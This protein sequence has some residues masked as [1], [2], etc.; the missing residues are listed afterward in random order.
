MARPHR[1]PARRRAQ[2]AALDIICVQLLVVVD[3]DLPLVL[4][5]PGEWDVYAWLTWLPKEDLFVMVAVDVMPIFC[6]VELPRCDANVAINFAKSRRLRGYVL[7]SRVAGRR[8]GPQG[9]LE[10]HDFAHQPVAERRAIDQLN[11]G[12]NSFSMAGQSSSSG[13]VDSP[14]RDVSRVAVPTWQPCGVHWVAHV[15]GLFRISSPWASI[16]ADRTCSLKKFDVIGIVLADNSSWHHRE[17]RLGR[18]SVRQ[19]LLVSG[20]HAHPRVGDSFVGGAKHAFDGGGRQVGFSVGAE[21]NGVGLVAVRAY[22]HFGRVRN[23]EGRFD[24]EFDGDPAADSVFAI[25]IVPDGR[26]VGEFA[27]DSLGVAREGGDEVV[28]VVKEVLR[29]VGRVARL[30]GLGLGLGMLAFVSGL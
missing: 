9:L 11:P 28:G 16:G 15:T 8:L 10:R 30:T 18:S 19:P 6:L 26:V 17:A 22:R 4:Q 29:R 20:E 24:G 2:D 3:Q 21:P 5:F 25:P 13:V 1:V 7:T 27:L 12:L 14:S 23:Q